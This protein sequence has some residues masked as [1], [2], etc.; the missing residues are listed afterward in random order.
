VAPTVGP[1]TGR[2]AR[3]VG[4]AFAG[5]VLL[6]ASVAAP[7]LAQPPAQLPAAML[8]DQFGAATALAN[9]PGAPV[10]VLASNREGSDAAARWERQFRAASAGSAVRVLSVADLQ[11]AP[12]LL[13][14]VIRGQMPKDT[15]ARVLLDWDGA[16]GRPLRGADRPLV[17]AAYGPDGRLRRWEALSL[18]GESAAERA[19]LAQA[20]VRAAGAP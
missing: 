3:S 13:R 5:A 14:G 1:V 12:R 20:L 10:V 18:T 9:P 8:R 11:G 17:A 6:A 16:L 19:A 7:A 2:V 4:V 15:A